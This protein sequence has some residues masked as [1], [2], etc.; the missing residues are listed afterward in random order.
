MDSHNRKPAAAES[1]RTSSQ[2]R[3]TQPVRLPVATAELVN[4][5][6]AARCGASR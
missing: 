6:L 3:H 1:A 4:R 2:A 5:L